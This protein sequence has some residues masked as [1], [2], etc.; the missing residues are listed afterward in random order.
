MRLNLPILIHE[1]YIRSH[2]KQWLQKNKDSISFSALAKV[3]ATPKHG[4]L[5]GAEHK[6]QHKPTHFHVL[7][8]QT[9]CIR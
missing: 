9:N 2:L 3:P 1:E 8:R 7:F 5:V 6:K 4:L